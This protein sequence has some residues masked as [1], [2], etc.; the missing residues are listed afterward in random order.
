[1]KNYDVVI[2]GAGPMGCKVGELLG[3]NHEVLIIDK[4]SEIGKPVQCTGFNS[5]RIFELSGVPKKVVI[6]KVTRSK[7]FSPNGTYMTLKSKIPFYVLDRELFDK[8][9]AKK[10]EKN[11]VE[12]KMRTEFKNFRREKDFLE[13][14]TNKGNFRTNLLIGADG[15]SSTVA[16]TANLPQPDNLLVGVQETIQEHF[17]L[18]CSELWFGSKVSPDFFGW[19]VPEGDDQARIGVA[20]SWKS[21]NYYQKFVEKRI[22]KN[23]KTKDKVSG[24]IRFGLIKSSV[25]DRVLLVGDAACQVKPFSGGGLIYGLIAAKIA[26]KACEKSL[27]KEK[28][29]YKFL[30]KNY[31][32]KWKERLKW[33]ILKGLC[34]SRIIHSSDWLLDFGFGV[35]KYL[36]PAVGELFDEDL[37]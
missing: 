13:I 17:D 30:K 31:E 36:S 6:N 7:F 14:K 34:I 8:E 28:Y 24:L 25:A 9:L 11:N 3:K 2:V 35:G 27:K 29:D 1:M 19:V 32:D 33:P 15:P 12:I 4:K 22:G 21:S 5:K 23:I 10:S 37:L 16:R 20:S 26:S 18:T